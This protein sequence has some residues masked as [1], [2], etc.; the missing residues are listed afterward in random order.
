MLTDLSDRSTIGYI[1]GGTPRAGI[2]WGT[3]CVVCALISASER[4]DELTNCRSFWLGVQG[5]GLHYLGTLGVMGLT[6]ATA[7]E[8]IHHSLQA[9]G[10]TSA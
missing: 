4:S 3:S 8:M 6:F 2:R 7:G 5:G 9:V 1:R 10:K